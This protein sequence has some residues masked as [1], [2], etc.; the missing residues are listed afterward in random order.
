M[1]ALG[2]E[3]LGPGAKDPFGL[4]SCVEYLP[5][6]REGLGVSSTEFFLCVISRKQPFFLNVGKC[7]SLGMLIFFT[8]ILNRLK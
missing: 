6:M 5:P 3:P 1:N 8:Q 4:R 7:I 2:F